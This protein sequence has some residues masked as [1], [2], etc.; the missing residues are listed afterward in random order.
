VNNLLMPDNT[1]VGLFV[2]DECDLAQ[3]VYLWDRLR[4]KGRRVA[5]VTV[6]SE[7]EATAG[8]T[9]ELDVPMLGPDEI[10]GIL[11]T[12]DLER[13]QADRYVD[14]CGGSPRAAHQIGINLKN[15]PDDLLRSPDTVDVWG[16][17]IVGADD[18]SSE[19]VA[20]RRRV[21]RHLALFKRVGW[22]KPHDNEAKAV[23]DMVSRVDSKITY[24]RFQEI[25]KDLRKR[26]L[27]Q[28]AG[29]LYLTPRIL[30]LKLWCEY[31]EYYGE[32]TDLKDLLETLPG[33]LRRWFFDM[34]R[35]A[36]SS[37]G[38][39]V[40]VEK[41]LGP[42]GPF[43]DPGYLLEGEGGDL[44]LALAEGHPEVS[45]SHLESVLGP[46]SRDGL[47][48][49]GPGRRHVVHA[50]EG[51]AMDRR[52]FA[53]AASLLLQLAEAETEEYSNNAT[54]V[55]A[56]LFSSGYGRAAPSEAAPEERF[57]T[58]ERALASTSPLRRRVAL[59][60]CDA[61][62][63]TSGI[64]RMIGSEYRGIQPPAK[65]WMPK[66]YAEWFDSIRRV[67]QLLSE[68]LDSLPEGERVEAMN[69]LVDHSA[70][71]SYYEALSDM[72]MGTVET[73]ARRAD[74][75][76][77]EFLERVIRLLRYPG[78]GMTPSNKKRWKGIYDTLVQ[79]DYA[80]QMRRFVV[81]QVWEDGIDEEAGS[82]DK[83]GSKIRSLARY[84]LS[85][86]DKLREQYSLILSDRAKNGYKFGYEIGLADENKSLLRELVVL[87]KS[88]AS[89]SIF[90][91]SGYLRALYDADR[92]LWHLTLEELAEVPALVALLPELVW[93]SGITE[94]SG[95][96]I[97][98][99]LQRKKVSS[100]SL[101]VFSVGSV[102]SALPNYIVESW[103]E[104]LVELGKEE[105]I[106]VALDLFHRY[107][108]WQAPQQCVPENLA[109]AVLLAGL[110]FII[111]GHGQRRT[112]DDYCWSEI[113]S[114][115]LTHNPNRVLE[116]ADIML[117]TLAQHGMRSHS[118]AIKV[119]N[120]I[121]KEKS[122]EVW[123]LLASRL[124]RVDSRAAFRI[125]EWLKGEWTY[126]EDGIGAITVLPMDKVVQWVAQD[127]LNRATYLASAVPHDIG[128]KDAGR[129]WSRTVLMHY[130]DIEDVRSA[131]LGNYSTGGWS[132]PASL[133]YSKRR[134]TLKA[135]LAW[136]SHPK[137]RRWLAEFI[138]RLDAQ[139]ERAEID[140]ERGEF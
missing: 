9:I 117:E 40:V 2:V 37:Q 6:F 123:N 68:S 86:L 52:L 81:M 42:G 8:N 48:K 51:M 138:S 96:L 73:I 92:D 111:L 50:L 124:G 139:I 64:V 49:L 122:A 46:M 47:L 116:L 127:P 57:P 109:I 94:R 45:L 100:S 72:V 60:A 56:G 38:A 23:A 140:E 89:P 105:D 59:R 1:F 58:L 114:H 67:W 99:L 18:P 27:V 136:E 14:L 135:V 77:V 41:L 31:W 25:L 3:S 87:I 43:E 90:F 91:F 103:I 71:L 106:S 5:L 85:H 63:T 118:T 12:Y 11:Q 35:Y 75:N 93:R 108:V 30:H 79:D 66:T 125:Q 98:S 7:R 88:S 113:A 104:M 62:L 54:G 10:T 112:M 134:E 39:K 29:T 120:R 110:P 107:Y 83:A 78:P 24:G 132:G 69:I 76:V 20:E 97:R 53:R 131:L 61:A 22:L 137:V 26:K 126:D 36:A 101:R 74:L 55:F 70:Q 28:G 16:R 95:I 84:S 13:D 44:F 4:D 19:G 133:H 121:A 21:L 34:F 128:E 129:S 32:S 65:Q 15:N 115:I 80:S 82:L 17:S 119:L 130:G 33:K 102:I